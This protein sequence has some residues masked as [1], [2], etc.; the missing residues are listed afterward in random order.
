MTRR[1]R[2]RLIAA[3]VRIANGVDGA[4]KAVAADSLRA[5]ARAA[6]VYIR[7]RAEQAVVARGA[8]VRVYAAAPNDARVIRADV[9]VVAE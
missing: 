7:L 4:E 8:V 3:V 2:E 5:G 6:D 9:A 1:R